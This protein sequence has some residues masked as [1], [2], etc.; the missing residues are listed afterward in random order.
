M[1]ET[2]SAPPSKLAKFA[3]FPSYDNPRADGTP[4]AIPAEHRAPLYVCPYD[5]GAAL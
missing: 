4:V 3:Q 2:G 1:N 5:P